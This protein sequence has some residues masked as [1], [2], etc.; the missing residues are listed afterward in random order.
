MY[1]YVLL[2]YDA[3]HDSFSQAISSYHGHYDP[4]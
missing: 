4:A 1:V 2:V 3:M